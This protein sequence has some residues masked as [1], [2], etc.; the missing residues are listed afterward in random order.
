[1]LHN[2]SINYRGE[3]DKWFLGAGVRNLEDKAP[4]LADSTEV[5]GV[6]S[7]PIGY[8]YDVYGREFFVNVQ[9]NFDI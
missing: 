8:G 4:P 6:K 3:D 1:M 5:L 7:R 2:V 9:Y